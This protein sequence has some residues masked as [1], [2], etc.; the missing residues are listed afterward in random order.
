MDRFKNLYWI[1]YNL[2]SV[3]CFVFF[4]PEA[5]GILAHWPGIEPIPPAL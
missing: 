5:H 4:G 2:A 3:L 1:C